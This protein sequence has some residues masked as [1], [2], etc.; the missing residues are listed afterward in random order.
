M[1]IEKSL[2]RAPGLA[3]FPIGTRRPHRSALIGRMLAPPSRPP[4]NRPPFPNASQ[5]P[6]LVLLTSHA[7]LLFS[8]LPSPLPSPGGY[9]DSDPILV[10]SPEEICSAYFGFSCAPTL[11]PLRPQRRAQVLRRSFAQPSQLPVFRDFPILDMNL[12]RHQSEPQL[13]SAA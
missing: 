13:R 9:H 1:V 5:R 10:F 3:P 2:S 6:V 7:P 12:N 11:S 8:F 4:I